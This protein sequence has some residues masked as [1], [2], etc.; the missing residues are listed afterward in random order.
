MRF[1]CSYAGRGLIR[2]V[3]LEK[4]YCYSIEYEWGLGEEER[5]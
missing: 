1:V 2:R 4:T 5:S 3:D